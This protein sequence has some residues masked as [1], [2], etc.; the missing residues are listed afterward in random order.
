[1]RIITRA[2]FILT[3]FQQRDFQCHQLPAPP[4]VLAYLQ[5]IQSV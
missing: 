2:K 3:P 4:R 1:L 5:L